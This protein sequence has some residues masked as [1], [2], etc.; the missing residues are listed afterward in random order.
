[1]EEYELIEGQELITLLSQLTDGRTLIRL[2]V[3]GTKF[4]RLVV[5]SDLK[6][7]RG[8]RYFLIENPEGF[9]EA[10]RGRDEWKF[11]LEFTGED[12][13]LYVLR[14]S[15]AKL[16]RG[17]IWIPFPEFMERH[18]R[19]QNFRL[20]APN[21]T[22]IVL[23]VGD[24]SF[25]LNVI[26]VSL[27]GTLGAFINIEGNK[28]PDRICKAGTPIK[29]VRIVFP[30]NDIMKVEIAIDHAV[31]KRYSRNLESKQQL[32]ALQFTDVKAEAEHK[33]T[34]II[35]DYQRQL[36]RKRVDF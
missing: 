33:L 4:E 11:K 3:L 32:C 30:V 29:N 6:K 25:E 9:S 26:D 31:I 28:K 14:T 22:K 24:E 12:G 2:Q 7:K 17:D 5:I 1:M 20:P 18:Q 15:E 27:G 21:G 19:R 8:Q 36:L 35:Y 10:V 34:E 23:E 16:T 13:I